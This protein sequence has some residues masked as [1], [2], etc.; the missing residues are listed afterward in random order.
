MYTHKD[1]Q[2]HR[3]IAHNHTH[4][5]THTQTHT[6]ANL[7]WN[8]HQ[9]YLTCSFRTWH[10]KQRVAVMHL[11]TLTSTSGFNHL[12]QSLGCNRAPHRTYYISIGSY[13]GSS[14]YDTSLHLPIHTLHVHAPA[15]WVCSKWCLGQWA[16]NWWGSQQKERRHW[17]GW[18]RPS[19]CI[20]KH[21]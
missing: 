1:T 15:D 14:L 7:T 17:G 4:I 21:T 19:S 9:R 6:S 13:G 8:V 11:I 3:L 20:E 12:C 5:N 16:P 10:V 2:T 18:G